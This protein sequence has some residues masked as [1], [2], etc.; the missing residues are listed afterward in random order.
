MN[1][2]KLATAIVQTTRPAKGWARTPIS[3]IASQT[4]SAAQ[5]RIASHTGSSLGARAS[6]VA[7]GDAPLGDAVTMSRPL[8]LTD[9]R[10]CDPSYACDRSVSAGIDNV[11][12][13]LDSGLHNLDQGVICATR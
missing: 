9:R 10:L 11:A 7:A 12:T 2:G 1:S 5:R 4:A 3:G 13:L 8:K 6:G